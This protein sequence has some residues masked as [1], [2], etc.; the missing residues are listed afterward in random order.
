MVLPF[1]REAFSS[2]N[3]SL[4]DQSNVMQITIKFASAQYQ[5]S[6]NFDLTNLQ[7][8]VYRVFDK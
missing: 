3:L 4:A 8:H 5:P 1:Q 6:A 2:Q 7:C